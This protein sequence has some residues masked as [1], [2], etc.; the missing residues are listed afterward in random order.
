LAE[1]ASVGLACVLLSESFGVT[2]ADFANAGLAAFAAE[3][4]AAAVLAAFGGDLLVACPLRGGAVF[5]DT[6]GT[7]CGVSGEAEAS[8]DSAATSANTSRSAISQ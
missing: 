8:R 2:T 6:G 1:A 7:G 5:A 3:V 4:R